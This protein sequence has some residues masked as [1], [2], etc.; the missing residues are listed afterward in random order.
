MAA[1]DQVIPAKVVGDAIPIE[2]TFQVPNGIT[3]AKAYLSVKE[4][5]DD[6]DADSIFPMIEITAAGSSSGQITTPT[7]V[8]GVIAMRFR[9][10]PAQSLLLTPRKTYHYCIKMIT[11]TAD[12]HTLEKGTIALEESGVDASV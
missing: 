10:S 4:H 1:L 9:I 3:A 5:E 7:S 8:A 12:P 2:R 6:L 11:S